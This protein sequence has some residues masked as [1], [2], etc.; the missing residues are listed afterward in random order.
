MENGKE[1]EEGEGMCFA[2]SIVCLRPGWMRGWG[3]CGG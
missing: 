1:E 3:R 2:M